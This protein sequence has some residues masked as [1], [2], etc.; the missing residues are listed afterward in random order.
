MSDVALWCLVEGDSTPFKVIAPLN[1]DIDDLKTLVRERGINVAERTIL[2]KD[3]TVWK[4][5]TS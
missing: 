1:A 4:V 2:A 3:L 5:S